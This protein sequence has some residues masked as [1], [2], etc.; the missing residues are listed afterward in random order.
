MVENLI[1][2][3]SILAEIIGR[4]M[5][6]KRMQEN[7]ALGRRYLGSDDSVIRSA[8]KLVCTGH[9]LPEIDPRLIE[10]LRQEQSEINEELSDAQFEVRLDG[11]EEKVLMEFMAEV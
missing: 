2:E 10:R 11:S 6:L 3:S 1:A 4:L 7:P 8:A 9:L 5:T